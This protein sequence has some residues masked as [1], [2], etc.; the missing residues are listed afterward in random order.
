MNLKKWKSIAVTIDVYDIL[1]R[2]ADENERS[3]SRQLAHMLKAID[4]EKR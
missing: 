1:K 4:E 2:I 3:V